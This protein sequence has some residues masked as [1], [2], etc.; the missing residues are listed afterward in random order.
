MTISQVQECAGGHGVEWGLR[1]SPSPPSHPVEKLQVAGGSVLC[2]AVPSGPGLLC[3]PRAPTPFP[4]PCASD[5]DFLSLSPRS[6]PHRLRLDFHSGS[7]VPVSLGTFPGKEAE[8]ALGQSGPVSIPLRCLRWELP[9]GPTAPWDLTSEGVG[10][11]DDQTPFR[12]QMA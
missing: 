6:L 7:T 9:S 1:L 8:P 3:V 12:G 2:P 4:L 5:G 11:M 10:L